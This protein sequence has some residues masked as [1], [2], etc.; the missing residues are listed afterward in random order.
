LH[1]VLFQNWKKT[2]TKT[3]QLLQQAY[4]EDAISRTQVF[5]WLR[6]FKR[7]EPPLKAIPARDDR[8]PPLKAIARSGRP[9]TWR[10]EEM[11]DSE[12]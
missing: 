12:V 5:D 11:I 2:A 9:S 1:Q 7:V 10:N 3:Y 8:Q 6:P 4:G